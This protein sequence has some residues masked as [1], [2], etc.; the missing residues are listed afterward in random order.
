MTL[1]FNDQVNDKLSAGMYYK[2]DYYPRPEFDCYTDLKSYKDGICNNQLNT[3]DNRRYKEKP[4]CERL[5]Q[6]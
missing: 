2:H 3:I 5:L 6:L 1:G 4:F